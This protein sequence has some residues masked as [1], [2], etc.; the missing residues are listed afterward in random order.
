MLLSQLSI[1]NSNNMIGHAAL[2]YWQSHP[3]SL[4]SLHGREGSSFPG[5]VSS[6][7]IFKAES[8]LGIPS[9]DCGVVIGYQAY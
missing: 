8:L 6:N 5:L 1:S 7:D 9:G 4:P 2:G 3:I